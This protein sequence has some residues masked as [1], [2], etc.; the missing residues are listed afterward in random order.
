MSLGY[1]QRSEWLEITW[2]TKIN[3]RRNEVKALRGRILGIQPLRIQNKNR[4]RAQ[5]MWYSG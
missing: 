5:L 1:D 3:G 2:K 4:V